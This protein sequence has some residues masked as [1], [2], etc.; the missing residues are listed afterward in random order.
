V[1]LL[2]D[3]G[4]RQHGSHENVVTWAIDKRD[5]SEVFGQHSAQANANLPSHTSAEPSFRHILASRI[6]GCS[7]CYWDTTC[8]TR[9]VGIWGSGICRSEKGV[10][11]FDRQVVHCTDF[12]VG[13]TEFDGDISF[14]LVLEPDRLHTRDGSDRRRLSVSDV[15]DCSCNTS[16]RF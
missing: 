6:W 13:V 8:S 10:S 15:T 3:G 9:E 2:T 5:V 14:Q 16:V 11:L 1:N 7:P 4:T 12:G